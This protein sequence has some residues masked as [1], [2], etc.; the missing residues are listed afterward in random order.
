M[1]IPLAIDLS[2]CEEEAKV[3]GLSSWPAPGLSNADLPAEKAMMRTE[4]WS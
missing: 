3:P 4:G 1:Y 2:N